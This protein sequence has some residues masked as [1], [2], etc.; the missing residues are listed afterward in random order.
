MK[1]LAHLNKYLYKYRGLLLLGVLFTVLSN[2][3]G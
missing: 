3:F 1:E 2:L